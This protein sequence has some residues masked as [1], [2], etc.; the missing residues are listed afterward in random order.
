[1]KTDNELQ[2][3][4]EKNYYTFFLV[5][6]LLIV[7]ILLSL[8]LKYFFGFG[9]NSFISAC[10]SYGGEYQTIGDEEGEGFIE[11]SV[12]HPN[13]N[14]FC[15]LNGKTYSF[16]DIKSFLGFGYGKYFCIEDC[17]YENNKNNGVACVC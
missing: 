15:I 5:L 3:K 16:D 10:N 12:Q 8:F 9:I 11:C 4:K 7:L 6:S 17:A 13:C 1:M 14:N 2:E